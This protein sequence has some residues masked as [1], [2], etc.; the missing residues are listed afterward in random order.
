MCVIEL[1][2]LG[3]VVEVERLKMNLDSWKS[4]KRSFDILNK[5]K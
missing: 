1:A 5:S 2:I 4:W 3:V